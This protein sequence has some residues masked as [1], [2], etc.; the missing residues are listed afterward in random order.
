[1]AQNNDREKV[2]PNCGAP[3]DKSSAKGITCPYCGGALAL[4][5][6]HREANAVDEIIPFAITEEE[7]QQRL[8]WELAQCDNV[9]LDAFNSL[10]IKA[11]K[12][13]VPVW[14][15]NGHYDASWSCDRVIRRKR[16]YIDRN[17]NVKKEEYKEYSP[18]NGN[19]KGKFT[20]LV[21]ASKEI[22]LFLTSNDD[23]SSRFDL[24]LID[25]DAVVYGLNVSKDVAWEKKGIEAY[26]NKI[27]G[28][29]TGEQA[30]FEYVNFHYSYSWDYSH[31]RSL[32]FSLW[33]LQYEYRGKQYDCRMN[34][35]SGELITFIHPEEKVK[36]DNTDLEPHI[37]TSKFLLACCCYA[38]FGVIFGLVIICRGFYDKFQ[39]AS[40]APLVILTILSILFG[41]YISWLKDKEKVNYQKLCK[42]RKKKAH[43]LRL[44]KLV[45]VPLL[46]RYHDKM[47]RSSKLVTDKTAYNDTVAKDRR[48]MRLYH[49]ILAVCFVVSLVALFVFRVV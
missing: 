9:P 36:V 27:A 17:G 46:S 23:K 28:K 14:S 44:Q 47:S 26:V 4:P 45:N 16:D 24:S 33:I 12:V 29:R 39:F 42:N 10:S 8:A 35:H 11:T 15:F 3:L 7:A 1:M 13:F 38:I 22:K 30:P 32:L 43:E 25:A 41:I 18:A 37:E 40:I 20:I 6:S 48:L 2:C 31:C 5:V 49:L 34:G 19:V 21:S